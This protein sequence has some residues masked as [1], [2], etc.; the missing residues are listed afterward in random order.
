M[1]RHHD[2]GTG[3]QFHIDNDLQFIIIMVESRHQHS[4]IQADMVLE[5]ELKVLH[6]DLT[7]GRRNFHLQA[8]GRKLSC[9]LG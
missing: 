9:T 7:A 4:S 1:K 3:L 8:A 2:H 5:K 6:L